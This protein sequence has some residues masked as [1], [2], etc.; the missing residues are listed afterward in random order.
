[1]QDIVW[2]K[3][4][5]WKSGDSFI[6]DSIRAYVDC[7]VIVKAPCCGLCFVKERTRSKKKYGGVN[8]CGGGWLRYKDLIPLWK[9]S[10][11][12]NREFIVVLFTFGKRE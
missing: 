3:S 12:G 8:Y 1:M 11:R 5:I 4:T 10:M 6:A 2:K 7:H 9:L